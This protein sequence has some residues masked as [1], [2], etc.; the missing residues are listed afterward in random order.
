MLTFIIILLILLGLFLLFLEFFV[1]PGMTVAG[2]G[3]LLFAGAGISMVYS[4]YGSTTG[5]IV[6]LST[7]VFAII[8]F[9]ISFKSGTWDKLMLKSSITGQVETVDENTIQPG[10]TG[11]C[12]TRLNPI[13]RV[14]VNDEIVEAKCPGQFVDEKTEV[15]VKEVFKTYIIVKQ[16]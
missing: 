12:I 16:K 4:N 8:L 6:L 5:H 10:D 2:I 11:I 1:T 9:I 13:G 3:G 14:R 7:I 15:I